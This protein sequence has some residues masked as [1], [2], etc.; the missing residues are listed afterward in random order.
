MPISAALLY[1]LT[2]RAPK[3]VAIAVGHAAELVVWEERTAAGQREV[4]AGLGHYLDRTK[5]F[6]SGGEPSEL[7]VV[8]SGAGWTIA[9]CSN[10]WGIDNR[11][12]V[13]VWGEL[14][15]DGKFTQQGAHSFG[16]HGV[17]LACSRVWI[18]GGHPVMWLATHDQHCEAH[19]L[20]LATG[21]LGKPRPLCRVW[22]A[23]GDDAF[24]ID[25][26]G[27]PV[28]VDGQGTVT[29][30][31][32]TPESDVRGTTIVTRQ[33]ATLRTWTAPFT[34]PARAI[35]L[36]K[37]PI[38]TTAPAQVLATANGV[39]L[40]QHQRGSEPY[41]VAWLDAKGKQID[42][43][44]FGA[45]ATQIAACAVGEAGLF[46]AWDDIDGLRARQIAPEGD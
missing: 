8:A 34:K 27:K 39:V 9:V 24:G 37:A 16:A 33:Q 21:V 46:C 30:A 36:P 7:A 26:A 29:R 45:R 28:H 43:A 2:Q 25:E 6:D 20:D 42:H 41:V 15:G 18:E 1:L 17:T 35:T 3:S 10:A 22:A 44:T 38:D 13:V 5:L 23:V 14:G 40:V 19:R 12:A 11:D 4:H 31:A 32:V